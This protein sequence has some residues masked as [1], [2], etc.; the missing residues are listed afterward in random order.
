M[1][2]AANHYKFKRLQACVCACVYLVSERSL[3]EAEQDLVGLSGLLCLGFVDDAHHV[4][5]A[6]G[7]QREALHLVDVVPILI[8]LPP[9]AHRQRL[10]VR[11]S[12]SY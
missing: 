10:R 11:V 6:L 3:D 7:Q 5:D 2:P 12:V 1:D 9:P 8:S 4:I